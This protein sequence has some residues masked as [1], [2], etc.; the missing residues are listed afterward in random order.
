MKG[1][2]YIY[3]VTFRGNGD[4]ADGMSPREMHV[5]DKRTPKAMARDLV[6]D[7]FLVTKAVEVRAAR[8]A[9]DDKDG[10]SVRQD[11]FSAEPAGTAVL[12]ASAVAA[13]VER[14]VPPDAEPLPARI[15]ADPAA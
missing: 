2:A 13:L 5:R 7:G 15:A 4:R 8:S 1:A 11:F 9:F 10:N 12:L 6:K 3:T 14:V